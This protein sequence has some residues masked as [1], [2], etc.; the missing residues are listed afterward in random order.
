MRLITR[1]DPDGLTCAVLITLEE[2]ISEIVFA[3]P[4]DMQDGKCAVHP[5]DIIC[6]LPFHPNCGLWF[7]HHISEDDKPD[8]VAEKFKGRYGLAPSAARLVY[9]YYQDPD[10]ARFENLLIET[11][12][13]DSAQLSVSDITF[14]EGYVL[15]FYTLDPRTGLG[16]GYQDYFK[17]L[18]E[19]LK[20]MPLDEIL[21][22]PDVMARTQRVIEDQGQFAGI[23][24]AHTHLDG[25]VIVTD[26]RG[27][28]D[29]P[30]G[31]RFLVYTMFPEGNVSMRWFQ[32]KDG[33]TVVAA[34]GHNILNR[35]CQTDIG[36]L[37]REYGGGGHRGAGTVQIA[38]DHADRVFAEI[39]Q[40]LKAAG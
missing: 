6:N 24:A 11:D 9:E 40:R 34:V 22:L 33:N 21:R 28:S 7:D 29:P 32:G 20:T 10:L 35:T 15:L 4:K 27:L 13:F 37:L 8:T 5:G 26:F 30:S 17:M 39:I 14:P 2:Q 12:R 31:N 25:N 18:I 38:N 19:A 16:G 3:H 23:L 36:H 1:A